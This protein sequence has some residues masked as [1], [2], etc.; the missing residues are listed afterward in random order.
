M[1]HCALCCSDRPWVQAQHGMSIF[2]TAARASAIVRHDIIQAFLRLLLHFT[3]GMSS[4]ASRSSVVLRKK[5]PTILH[6]QCPPCYFIETLLR[7]DASF[8]EVQKF[9]L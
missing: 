9:L 5:T 1:G 8:F 7:E 3:L 4:Q 2:Q 6:L